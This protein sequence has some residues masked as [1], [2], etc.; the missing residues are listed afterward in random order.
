M[1]AC[2]KKRFHAF[3]CQTGCLWWCLGKYSKCTF[4]FLKLF[5]KNS[6]FCFNN[7]ICACANLDFHFFYIPKFRLEISWKWTFLQLK[8]SD[9]LD[10]T[11]VAETHVYCLVLWSSISTMKIYFN[12]YIRNMKID[13]NF[14]F[15]WR[16][17]TFEKLM[18]KI[19]DFFYSAK[20][21]SHP[22]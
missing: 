13:F 16:W 12:N 20:S 3:F 21:F 8:I 15:T 14:Y 4:T 2:F 11:K 17:V 5:L 10:F 7:F 19:Y 22:V 18:M 1:E 9:S 6:N